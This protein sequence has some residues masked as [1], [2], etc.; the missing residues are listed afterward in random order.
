MNEKAAKLLKNLAA[1]K[2]EI[3][4]AEALLT[5]MSQDQQEWEK[6]FGYERFV[7][8]CISREKHAYTQGIEQGMSQGIAQGERKRALE[9][10]RRMLRNCKLSKKEIAEITQLSLDEILQLQ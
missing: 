8:D 9:V 10:A 5:T 6:Q 3:G 4:M 2:E 1:R 7:H